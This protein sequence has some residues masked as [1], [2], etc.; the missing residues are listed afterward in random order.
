MRFRFTSFVFLCF[1]LPV[2]LMSCSKK[3]APVKSLVIYPAPPDTTRIQYLTSFSS[4]VDITGKRSSL[5]STVVGEESALELRKPY[6][7]ASSPGKLFICDP[8]TGGV[9]VIDLEKKKFTPFIPDGK[10]KLRM[11]VNCCT[12]EE[13]RLYV[14]DAERGDVVVFDKNLKYLASLS[15]PFPSREFK[16]LDVC[17]TA[18]K[19]WVTNSKGAAVCLYN[20]TDFTFSSVIPDSLPATSKQFYNPINITAGAGKVYVTDFGDFKIKAFDESGQF[21]S[22][23]GQY[24]KAPGQFV[25]PKGLAVDKD[26]VLYVVDAGFENVQLFNEQGKLLMYFGGPY[27]TPGDMWL[28]AKVHIDYNNLS[29]Y[30][31]WVSREYELRYLIFVSNQ[32]GPDKI[33]VY[34][35]VKPAPVR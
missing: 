17:V 21:L 8:G 25:R 30:K 4:S 1:L 16:P 12:D 9:A 5:K 18:D 23:I 28:P 14:A 34:G 27:K 24:G 13:G 3:I 2:W 35:A 11:P 33:S 6:G 26:Q 32:Y 31:K 29:Y 19:I 15:N 10:G 7:I 20:K 22:E